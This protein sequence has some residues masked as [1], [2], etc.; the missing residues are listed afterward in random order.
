MFCQHFLVSENLFIYYVGKFPEIFTSF[1]ALSIQEL[2]LATFEGMGV[3][4]DCISFYKNNNPNSVFEIEIDPI[5]MVDH[6]GSIYS[7]LWRL[8]IHEG[9][10]QPP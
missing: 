9:N 10:L 2:N 4:G 8:Q 1:R 6:L 7:E 3:G 5:S